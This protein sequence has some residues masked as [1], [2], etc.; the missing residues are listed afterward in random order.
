MPLLSIPV[1]VPDKFATVT[2]IV[3]I[4]MSKFVNM[5][6]IVILKCRPNYPPTPFF[7]K[8]MIIP[9]N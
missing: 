8:V 4:K 9:L 7:L 6:L 3:F 5:T 1:Y 2:L